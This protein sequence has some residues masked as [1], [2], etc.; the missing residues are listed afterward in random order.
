M[1]KIL[2]QVDNHLIYWDHLK[3][4]GSAIN[5]YTVAMAGQIRICSHPNDREGKE[6]TVSTE[7][8]PKSQTSGMRRVS[9]FQFKSFK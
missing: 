7:E 4:K 1:N 6:C 3:V 2:P 5:N 8:M 9:L